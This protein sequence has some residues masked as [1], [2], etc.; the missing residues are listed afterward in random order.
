[1]DSLK[2]IIHNCNIDLSSKRNFKDT[3]FT[4]YWSKDSS[5]L[6]KVNWDKNGQFED[7]INVSVIYYKYDT[8]KRETKR[9]GFDKSGNFALFDFEPILLTS[10]NGNDIQKESF[11]YLN[12]LL[13]RIIIKRDSAKRILEELSYDRNLNL[14]LRTVYEY[15]DPKNELYIKR[16]DGK[17]NLEENKFGDAVHYFKYDTRDKK[18]IVE[19]RFY[20]SEFKL[21][22]SSHNIS[23]LSDFS[24]L[25]REKKN[26]RIKTYYYNAQ[27]KIV[28]E[29]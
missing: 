9:I 20:N 18:F 3:L 22:D 28:E 16:F 29:E 1:M 6:Y 12:K 23:L 10:Y 21:K 17:G 11:N 19:E 26:G 7:N 24:I 2:N 5:E 15:N 27:N 13:G 4:H 14:D 8:L 25:K